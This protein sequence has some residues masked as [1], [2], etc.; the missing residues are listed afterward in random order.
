MVVNGPINGLDMLVVIVV[1]ALCF[2]AWSVGSWMAWDEQ[3]R[4]KRLKQRGLA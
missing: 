1:I 4:M 2:V 3:R